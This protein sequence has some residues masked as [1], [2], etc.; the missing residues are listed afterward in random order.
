[1]DGNGQNAVQVS[2]STLVMTITLDQLTG[3]VRVTG[4]IENRFVAY[5]MLELAKDAVRMTCEQKQSGSR[6]VLPG[7]SAIGSA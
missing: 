2:S 3:A 5:G 7:I 1:M 6:I 4:P